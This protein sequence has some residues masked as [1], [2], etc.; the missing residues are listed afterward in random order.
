MKSQNQT[1]I[2]SRTI[3]KA[4]VAATREFLARQRQF[5]KTLH[6]LRSLANCDIESLDDR[7]EAMINAV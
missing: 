5:N 1:S 7:V 4:A 2:A 6:Q 3:T